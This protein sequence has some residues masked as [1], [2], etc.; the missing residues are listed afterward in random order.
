M[1]SRYKVVKTLKDGRVGGHTRYAENLS[2]IKRYATGQNLYP[3]EIQIFSIT[4]PTKQESQWILELL[5]TRTITQD[6]IDNGISAKT[7]KWV[8]WGV[9]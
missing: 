9:Q 2:N 7:A 1:E 3:C 4:N 8:N 6:D 5:A